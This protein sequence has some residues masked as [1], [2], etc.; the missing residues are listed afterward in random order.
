MDRR[1]LLLLVLVLFAS[2][3][4]AE[5]AWTTDAGKQHPAA[6]AE[7]RIIRWCNEAGTH[8]RFA[9]AN[10]EIK[11][12]HPCGELA[13]PVSCDPSGTRM[14]GK[15]GE[16]PYAFKDC[17]VGP[18]IK[19]ERHGPVITENYQDPLSPDGED[20]GDPLSTIERSDLA[21]E[22]KKAK[23]QQAQSLDVQLQRALDQMMQ[24]LLSIDGYDVL[25]GQKTA[26]RA[27]SKQRR[28]N[29]KQIDELIRYVDPQY[30]RQLEKILRSQ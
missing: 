4:N 6:S 25:S 11:G 18:R 26:R 28:F 3:A 13:M 30:Q 10:I 29:E 16:T 8:E 17:A 20:P 9:S 5:D 22:M 19:I 12:Y 23:D 27:P 14:I 15:S 24:Q 2:R 7:N 21:R 1:I